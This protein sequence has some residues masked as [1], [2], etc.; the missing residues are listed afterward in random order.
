MGK[1]TLSAFFKNRSTVAGAVAGL[2]LGAGVAA[3]AMSGFNGQAPGLGY[4]GAQLIRAADLTPVKPPNGAPM[5]F[6]DMIERVSPAVVSIET[7][8]KMKVPSGIPALPGFDFPG[9][10]DA[11]PGREQEVRGAGSGFIISADGYVVTNNH[12]IQGA[13]EI[14]V[15]LTND[16]ELKAKVIG[17]D[18]AT[19]LAVLKVEGHDFPFVRW[20]LEH[21]PRVGDWVVAVGNP[22][23]FSNT[24]TAG[25][26]SAYGRDLRE[27]G[28]SYIDYLQIDAAINRGN[29]GGPTFDLY[30]RVIGV[31]TAIVTPS[32]ANAGVGFAIP[33]DVANRI[34]SQLIRGVK[35]ERG[36]IGVTI[37]PVTQE[38]AEALNVP[39]TTGAY[40][41]ETTKSGPADKAGVQAGDIVKTVNGQPV[42]SPTELTRRIADVKVGE[43]I[44]LGVVRN[45]KLV[46]L[47]LTAALRPSEEDLAKGLNGGETAPE[48]PGAES[49]STP[50]V[51]GLSVKT[52]TPESRRTYGLDA[53]VKG[54]VITNVDIN[55]DGGQKG[56]KPGD[57]I[58]LADQRPITTQADFAKVV[59][60][61]KKAGRPA[62]LLLV[63]RD[64]RNIPLPLS[65]KDAPK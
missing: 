57:V 20:E 49:T 63:S 43:K 25:I 29:S 14:V 12:V 28:T 26:V 56:L 1:N 5:S 10:E 31:N 41:T 46:N 51:M 11:A 21:K 64:G 42:K 6:A 60:D 30:G 17:R 59:D 27:S 48:T 2:A 8:G 23:N 65:L 16:K 37:S 9:Q 35:I 54:V 38:N 13:D 44:T 33:A 22:F 36:Y 50:S 34:T 4:D 45:G 61:L 55:S 53:D 40:I 47:T 19:D 3:A 58:V 52:L 7:K 15:K 18:P 39:D 24:A 32:G 62:I